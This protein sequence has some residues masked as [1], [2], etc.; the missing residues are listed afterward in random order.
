MK[1]SC[2][3]FLGFLISAYSY[4]Q[5]DTTNVVNSRQHADLSASQ[6]LSSGALADVRYRSEKWWI[7]SRQNILYK[8]YKA[9]LSSVE[10]EIM[11]LESRECVAVEK[12]DTIT[13]AILWARDFT[14]KKK[15]NELV[16]NK[17]G[18]PSY[19]SLR[20]MIESFSAIDNNIVLT[21]GYETFREIKNGWKIEPPTRLKYFHTWTRNNGLWKLTTKIAN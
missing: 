15:H 11:D 19:L 18:L 7:Y 12:K 1:A 21:S 6:S 10:I 8:V 13:L 5:A 2:V 9:P 20:R 4:S 3:S 16:Q 14:Q 17:H